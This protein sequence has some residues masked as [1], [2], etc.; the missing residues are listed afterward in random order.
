MRELNIN[1]VEQVSGGYRGF[2]GAGAI[3]SV[4]GFGSL[5]TPIGPIVAA[6]S[7]GSA[8]GLAIAQLWSN[9]KRK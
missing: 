9:F 3:V 8:G 4:V 7:I 5:F 6:V 2:V 1:E